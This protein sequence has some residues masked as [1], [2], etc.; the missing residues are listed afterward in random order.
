MARKLTLVHSGA[1]ISLLRRY[2][3]V[4]QRPHCVSSL[5]EILLLVSVVHGHVGWRVLL[6]KAQPFSVISR[7]N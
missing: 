4:G 5:C 1:V 3:A 7:P 6:S 2:S